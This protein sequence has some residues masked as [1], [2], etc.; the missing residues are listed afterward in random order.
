MKHRLLTVGDS[1]TYGDEL[2]DIHDAWPY[3]LANLINYNVVNLGQSG[4]SNTSILRR[5]IV[6]LA[7]LANE[8][9][10]LV[11]IGWTS[12]GRVEWKDDIG[13]EYNLWPGYLGRSKFFHDHPWRNDWLNYINK[14]HNSEYLYQQYL[15]NVISLQSYLKANN[16]PYVMLNIVNNEYYRSSSLKG[17]G[18]LANEIDKNNFPGWDNFGMAE[19][20]SNCPKGPGGHPLEL[21]HQQ[22]A[23]RIYEHIRTLEWV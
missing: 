4:C 20:A 10:D 6:E 16:I 8:K 23:N 5:T 19:I 1:F 17:L 18:Y 22:I 13:V 2:D 3:K 21:G 15:V 12:A 14:Y 9:Y 7:G 11:V